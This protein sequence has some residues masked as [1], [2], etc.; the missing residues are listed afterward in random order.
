[1]M[2]SACF[3]FSIFGYFLIKL[4]TY[5]QNKM[6]EEIRANPKEFMHP[7]MERN[8]LMVEQALIEKKINVTREKLGMPKRTSGYVEIRDFEENYAGQSDSDD[9]DD[10]D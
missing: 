1:M 10:D 8:G 3:T 4:V 5:R 7:K 2:L 9:D 6:E